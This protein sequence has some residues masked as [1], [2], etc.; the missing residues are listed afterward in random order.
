M[1]R[2]EYTGCTV[3][4]KTYSKSHKLKKRLH[5]APENQRIFPNTQ[6]AII[7]EQVFERVQELR[8]NKRRPSKDR[9]GKDYSLAC[10]TVLT[11]GTSCI[12]ATTNNFSPKQ[13]H[14]RL[15]QLQEQHGNLFLHILSGKKR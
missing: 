10:S 4:F 5:N 6:P 11:A 8:E 9:N 14:Y 15:L 2:P 1:E 12:S 7:E 13:D 3:N